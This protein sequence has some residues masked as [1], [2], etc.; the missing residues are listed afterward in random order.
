VPE[1]V[2]GRAIAT[3]EEPRTSM[4]M[5]ALMFMTVSF[6]SRALEGFLT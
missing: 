1:T 2:T 6:V 3:D 4:V 5:S